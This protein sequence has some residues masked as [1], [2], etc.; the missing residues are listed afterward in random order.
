MGVKNHETF[1]EK[2]LQ[3]SAMG[4]SGHYTANP[5][6][7]IVMDAERLAYVSKMSYICN[8]VEISHEGGAHG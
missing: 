7:D 6:Q 5:K 2:G 8:A 1:L 4:P 3:R